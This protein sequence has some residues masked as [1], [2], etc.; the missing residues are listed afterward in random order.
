MKYASAAAFRSALERRLLTASQQTGSSL[1]RL[2]KL[3]V[4]DRLM[5]RLLV[6]APDRWILKGALALDFRFGP[7]FRTTKDL[8]LARQDSEV[9][10]TEDFLAAQ[11]VDLGDYFTF[12]IEKTGLHDAVLEGA[13]LRYRATAQLAGRTFEDVI[14]DIGFSDPVI[15]PPEILRGPD[16]LSFADIVPV[17]VP[18]LS[19]AQHVAEKVHAYT[20]TYAAQRPSSRVKDLIDLVLIQSHATFEVCDLRAALEATFSGRASHPLPKQ[21]PLPPANWSMP[22]R[23][24]ASDA[25]IS[26]AISIAQALV[27]AFLDPILSETVPVDAHWDPKL[28]L[29]EP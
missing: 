1:T 15:F 25:R 5:A 3:V 16:L 20:R 10:A 26:P 8:D 4:F 14:I 23:N 7:A 13:A 11:A 19:L 6:V 12:A 21:L 2:R 18:A 24:L 22:Y 28:G 9:A 27:A 17:E 29:W